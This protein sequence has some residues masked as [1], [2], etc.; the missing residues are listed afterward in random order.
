MYGP[1]THDLV[2]SRIADRQLQL[3]REVRENLALAA[4]RMSAPK[5]AD[6]VAVFA[7]KGAWAA[8]AAILLG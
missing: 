7:L 5:R 6:R 2:N 3:T 4:G 1:M 8:V